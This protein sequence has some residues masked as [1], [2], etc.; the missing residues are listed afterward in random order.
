[1]LPP[2]LERSASAVAIP[3]PE[4]DGGKLAPATIRRSRILTR[5]YA[6][7]I[8]QQQEKAGKSKSAK[9]AEMQAKRASKRDEGGGY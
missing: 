1:M 6:L 7:R 5:A 9:K 3:A 8:V 4:E 2:A